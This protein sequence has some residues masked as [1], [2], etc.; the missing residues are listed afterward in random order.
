M[1]CKKCGKENKKEAAYCA[2]CGTKLAV[3]T[4]NMQTSRKT[5]VTVNRSEKWAEAKPDKEKSE[6]ESITSRKEEKK[7][8]KKEKREAKKFD[9]KIGSIFFKLFIWLLAVAILAAGVAAALVYFNLVEI[10]ILEDVMDEIGVER[11]GAAPEESDQNSR[12]ITSE[13]PV[14]QFTEATV[15]TT[16][17]P[18]EAA[19][20]SV[21]ERC[22]ELA[23]AGDL[24]AA[25]E[26]LEECVAQQN[27]DVR[28]ESLLTEYQ[29]LLKESILTTTADYAAAGQYRVAIQTLNEAWRRYADQEYYEAAVAYRM[30]FGIYN[31]SVFAAGK[32]NTILLHSD[33]TTEICGDNTFE[34][35][36]ANSWTDI[37]AVSMGDRHVIGLKADG[38]VVAAGEK[39]YEQCDVKS[40]R[41][42]AAISAGDVHTVA[43]MKDGTLASTGYDDF[44][45]CDVISLMSIAGDKRI[46]SVAAGYV[47]TLALLEDGTVAACGSNKNGACDVSGWNNIA[48]IYAG[49]EFSAGLK[50]DGTVV[51]TGLKTSTWDLSEWTDIV[52]LAAGDY[53]LVG[54]KAD[55]TVLS[56]DTNTPKNSTKVK[57]SV[58]DWTNIVF[59]AAG[60]DHTVALTEKGKIL[61]V[62]SND[63]GQSECSGIRL[64]G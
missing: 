40:W 11:K 50:E 62:G 12:I 51:V 37:T 45:Q 35:L 34:E 42:V 23:A 24:A 30:D 54:L 29:L 4:E 46:V 19:Y 55:G 8:K 7:A 6:S 57:A 59:I 14:I 25:V 17:D 20:R 28:Y 2:Y 31:T 3:N 16:E 22:R 5:D 60:H 64:F 47:H 63:Y 10:P 15:P 13:N 56:T 38:T 43:L 52:N 41:N 48:A 18:V 32:Y 27:A 61:C 44:N 33:G 58:S 53:F 21:E 49:T 9:P 39:K 26:Y 1:F 36:S